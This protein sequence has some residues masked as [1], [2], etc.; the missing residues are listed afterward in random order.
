MRDDR[1]YVIVNIFRIYYQSGKEIEKLVYKNNLIRLFVIKSY[2][3]VKGAVLE[4]F[5]SNRP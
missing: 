1:K 2:C 3:A 4:T 5:Q